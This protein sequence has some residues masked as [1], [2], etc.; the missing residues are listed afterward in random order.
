[1]VRLRRERVTEGNRKREA[2]RDSRASEI[3]VKI[4]NVFLLCDMQNGQMRHANPLRLR[5]VRKFHE[6]T[7]QNINTFITLKV[8]VE[9]NCCCPNMPKDK[10]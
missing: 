3:R 6:D 5:K 4:V 8:R 7:T 10:N 1:M 2:I 9:K